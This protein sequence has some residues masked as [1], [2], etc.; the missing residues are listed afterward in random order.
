MKRSQ[1]RVEKGSEGESYG[2]ITHRGLNATHHK[3]PTD[4]R[5]DSLAMCRGRNDVKKSR[6]QE[7][8]HSCPWAAPCP[9]GDRSQQA[10]QGNKKSLNKSP[11]GSPP[12]G[13]AGRV[14]RV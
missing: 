14:L 2:Q 10:G 8:E 4:G 5:V 1:P 13:K 12:E 3:P 11:V 7:Q 6:E 9:C